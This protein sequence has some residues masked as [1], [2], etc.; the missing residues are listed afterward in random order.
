MKNTGEVCSW[1]GEI[2]YGSIHA[3]VESLGSLAMFFWTR[4][5]E[6]KGMGKSSIYDFQE[7]GGKWHLGMTSE[8]GLA[9]PNICTNISSAY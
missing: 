2:S 4:G 8:T 7:Q 5:G 1:P 9:L 6:G 3:P